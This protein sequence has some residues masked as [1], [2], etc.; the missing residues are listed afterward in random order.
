MADGTSKAVTTARNG[1][2][3][4][5]RLDRPPANAI[6]MATSRALGEAFRELRD[7]DDLRVGIVSTGGGRSFFRGAGI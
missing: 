3:F 4:E 6:D 1:G 7:D 2:V 5:V